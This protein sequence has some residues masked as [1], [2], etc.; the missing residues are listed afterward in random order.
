MAVIMDG[1]ALRNRILNELKIRVD[2]M[3]QK[4]KLVAI[5]VGNDPASQIYVR[6]K[7]KFAEI[8]GIETDVIRIPESSTTNDLVLT[9]EKLNNDKSVNAILV[10]LPLPK[11]ID[12]KTVLN[13]VSETKDVDGFTDTNIG[14]MFGSG[15]NYIIPC[16]PRG[17]MEILDEYKIDI[18]GKNAVIIGRSD[19]VGKPTAMMLLNK[20]A[21]VTICHSKT[22]NISE[23]TRM[24]DIIVAATGKI[25][26]T[27]DMIKPGCVLLDVGMQRD[28]NGNLH[29]DCDFESCEKIAGYI[30]PT[31]GGIGPMT[32]AGLMENAVDI[33]EKNM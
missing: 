7:E 5:L 32:I 13:T 10:Q 17:I 12:T 20:N 2:K 19:I 11:H 27:G 4:P 31:P 21:T 8:A 25:K 24:A 22:Q 15:D 16:T 33:T 9:I 30:T 1:I 23:Y 28:E 18:V 26:I 3:S 14:K 6:N 29:G